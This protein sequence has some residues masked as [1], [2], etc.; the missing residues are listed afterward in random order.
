MLC[1]HSGSS[2]KTAA[3]L[4][5]DHFA[6]LIFTLFAEAS[7]SVRALSRLT[8]CSVFEPKS[9]GNSIFQVPELRYDAVLTLDGSRQA[10]KVPN[11]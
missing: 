2:M 4:R 6:K 1:F 8:D 7:T 5:L 9:A 11:G 3:L 10:F